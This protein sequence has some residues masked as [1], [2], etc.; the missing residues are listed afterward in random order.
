MTEQ[1]IHYQS[2]IN[3]MSRGYDHKAMAEQYMNRD[4]R[5]VARLNYMEALKLFKQAVEAISIYQKKGNY[6]DAKVAKHVRDAKYE[7]E[8]CI[9]QIK[10]LN[11]VHH[12]NTL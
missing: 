2:F 1:D 10:I 11:G 5:I 8:Q 3:Y 9:E 12:L 6:N 4:E 7:Y